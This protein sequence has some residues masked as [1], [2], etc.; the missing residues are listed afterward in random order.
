MQKRIPSA[1]LQEQRPVRLMD[2]MHQGLRARHY[3]PRTEDTYCNWV[4]RFIFFHKKKHPAQMAEAEVNAFVSHLAVEAHVSASTQTQALS[5]I[6]FLYKR[7]LGI[8]L[9]SLE[10]I[11]RARKPRILPVVL[12][13]EEVRAVLDLLD[14]QNR[15]I[16]HLMYGTGL[17]LSECLGL[18]VQDI[19]FQTHTIIVRDG[20][21]EQ[22]RVTMLPRKLKELLVVHLE[23]IRRIHERDLLEG[24]GRVVMPY[25]L[26]RKYPNAA[27]EWRWQF[28]FPQERRWTAPVTGN[29]GRHHVDE[30]IVQ[31]AVRQAVVRTGMT[32]RATTHSFRHAF[33]THLLEDGYDIR[34]VQELLGHKSVKTTMIYTHVLNR[35]PGAIRSPA[36]SL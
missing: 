21:G 11:I 27:A 5:A 18:R 4:R 28:I 13:R 20:K 2:R 33:A 31:R 30:T 16:A 32:K 26:D 36:D 17:R 1:D 9:G 25:A 12:T 14:G 10:D 23:R 29:Q 3:S 24:W 6:I 34:T 15:L 7:V 35:G 8:D 22:D 19:D